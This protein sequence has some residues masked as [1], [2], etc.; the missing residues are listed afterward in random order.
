VTWGVG[1]V[2]VGLWLYWMISVVFSNFHSMILWFYSM[3]L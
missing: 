3:I 1:R 2:R